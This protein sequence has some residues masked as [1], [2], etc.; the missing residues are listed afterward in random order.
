MAP[1]GSRAPPKRAHDAAT[2][3]VPESS[4]RAAKKLFKLESTQQPERDKQRVEQLSDDAEQESKPSEGPSS[5]IVL[6]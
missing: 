1:K 2:S 6:D 3:D 4:T 5:T